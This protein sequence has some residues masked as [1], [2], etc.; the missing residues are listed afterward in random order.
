MCA[1]RDCEVVECEASEVPAVWIEKDEMGKT[2]RLCERDEGQRL[3]QIEE[4]AKVEVNATSATVS[5]ELEEQL[6]GID[7]G[8]AKAGVDNFKGWVRFWSSK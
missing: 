6:G 4:E 5:T 8:G 2:T 1:I 7:W 3:A